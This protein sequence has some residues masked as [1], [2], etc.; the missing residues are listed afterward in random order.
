MR[1]LRSAWGSVLIAGAMSFQLTACGGASGGGS[2]NERVVQNFS[3]CDQKPDVGASA[4]VGNSSKTEW[5]RGYFNKPYDR[6]D[7][8]AVL[9]ASS[10]STTSYV[11]SL[12]IT[13]FK[14]PRANMAGLCPTYFNLAVAPPVYQGV[15]NQIAG[16]GGAGN[17]G[18]KLAGLFF[19]FC[20]TG[21]DAACNDRR[22][23]QPTILLDEASDRWTIVHE[24]MHYNFNQGRK[25]DLNIRPAGEIERAMRTATNRIK[26]IMA[27]FEELPDRGDLQTA[28]N[29]LREL[30][31]VAHEIGVRRDLEEVSIEA[32]LIDQWAAG[33]LKNVDARTAP[34][35]GVWYMNYSIGQYLGSLPQLDPVAEKI[36]KEADNR[37]WAEIS[38]HVKESLHMVEESRTNL[39][40]MVETAKFKIKA[41]QNSDDDSQFTRTPSHLRG[42]LK[43]GFGQKAVPA[44]ISSRSRAPTQS[45]I[46]EARR[47][48]E[49]HLDSHD[50]THLRETFQDLTQELAQSL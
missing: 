41:A 30:F 9:D 35:S 43:N 26:T 23:I 11:G 49:A 22:M 21:T 38:Q 7:L 28:A 18:G 27:G 50:P 32:M 3:A 17:D 4:L 31:E 39:K 5:I 1:V 36:S 29:S 13:I 33:D 24:M 48:M 37:G 16:G 2:A 45:E 15:W 44:Q 25:A 12:G 20:G 46:A 10:V 40:R 19:E 6:F 34:A 8:E 42:T 47:A 14:V